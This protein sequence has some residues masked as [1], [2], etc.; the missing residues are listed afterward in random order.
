MLYQLGDKK[1]QLQGEG[2]FI[3]PNAA[4]IGDVCLQANVSIWFSVVLRGDG[5][6]I[7]IGAGSNIQD[8]SVLHV[9]PGYPL[10]LAENVTV[11]H[12]VML[13]GCTVG[14]GSLIG[15][16]SVV[17]NGA[18]IGKNCIIGANALVTENMEIPDNS[19]VVGSPAKIKR[20][21]D[22]NEVGQM[23]AAH[24]VQNGQRYLK[25]LRPQSQ[26]QLQNEQ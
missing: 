8:G 23:L 17:L 11:G 26:A 9:D 1:V 15:I 24:Y 5:D 4:V 3:A 25:E 6:H 18:K 2:H 10:K 14:E 13:H 20:Q 12:K 16:N 7:E 22:N 21:L 19:L